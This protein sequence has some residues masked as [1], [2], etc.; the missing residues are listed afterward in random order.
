MLPLSG[1]LRARTLRGRSEQAREGHAHTAAPS[2]WRRA[3]V[4]SCPLSVLLPWHLHLPRGSRVPVTGEEA[5]AQ[6][7]AARPGCPPQLARESGPASR[8]TGEGAEA[9]RGEVTWAAGPSRPGAE[10]GAGAV[11][12]VSSVFTPAARPLGWASP[13]LFKKIYKYIYMCFF[14]PLFWFLIMV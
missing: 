1:F 8:L 12:P 6:R 5:E 11:F 9:P 10:P 7:G 14:L 2:G 3:A 13:F 4:S